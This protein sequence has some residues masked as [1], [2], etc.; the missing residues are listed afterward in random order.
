M[1]NLIR[2]R[3][4]P[5]PG[6]PAVVLVL[7]MACGLAAAAAESP[8][9]AEKLAVTA[10]VESLTKSAGKGRLILSFRPSPEFD[11]NRTPPITVDIESAPGIEW[12]RTRQL[13]RDGK[14]SDSSQYFGKILPVEF[15]YTLSPSARPEAKVKVT[16]FYCSK[17]DGYCARE[18][19]PLV[20]PLTPSS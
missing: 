16:Y 20:V 13:P 19:K 12:D 3:R 1:R 2:A 7:A 15:T 14:P 6:A 8:A 18:N 5:H 11:I 9:A 10:K 4:P 17:K